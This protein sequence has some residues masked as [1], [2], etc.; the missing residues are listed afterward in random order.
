MK[1]KYPIKQNWITAL[2]LI[3]KRPI[4]ILPFVIIA[5]M[6]VLALELLYFSPQTPLVFLAGPVIRKFFGEAALHYPAN[7]IVIPKVFYYVQ[8]MIY[9]L[10]GV[11]LSAVTVNMIKNMRAELPLKLK[12]LV[13]NALGRYWAFAAYGFLTA[14]LMTLLKGG[15]T[16]VFLKAIKAGSTYLPGVILRAAPFEASL[17]LFVANIIMSAFLVCTVPIIVIKKTSFL[18]ALGESI[19][20]GWRNFR[21]VFL[22]ILVPYILFLPVMLLKSFPGTLFRK[23]FPEVIPIITLSGIVVALFAECIVIICVS[24]FVLDLYKET[25]EK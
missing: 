21:I 15:T 13:K 1:Y 3:V 7:L 16:F 10:F 2:A 17:V 4:L 23:T 9:V 6:E 11:L 5:F 24:R 18:R 14:A 25:A 20:I 22:T 8:I 12:A 19:S